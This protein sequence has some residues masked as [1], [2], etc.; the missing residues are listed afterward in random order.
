MDLAGSDNDNEPSSSTVFTN[1]LSRCDT[2][3]I[4]VHGCI[5]K[6]GEVISSEMRCE[7]DFIQ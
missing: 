5:A 7:D 4:V 3:I 6:A 2:I 1:F